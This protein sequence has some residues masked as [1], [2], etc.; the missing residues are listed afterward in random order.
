[1][2]KR[3]HLLLAFFLLSLLLPGAAIAEDDPKPSDPPKKDDA[4][5]KDGEPKPDDAPKGDDEPAEDGEP[6]EG[7]DA[8]KGDGEAEPVPSRPGYKPSDPPVPTPAGMTYLEGGRA[9]IGSEQSFL[10][11]LLAGRPPEHQKL[12]RYE[13]P[14]HAVLL[15]PYFMAK[16]EVT[17][18]QYRVFLRDHETVYDT[19]GGSLANL[20]EIAAHLAKLSKDEQKHPRQEVWLQFYRANKDLIWKAFEARMKDFLVKRLDDTVD[21]IATAK[22]LRFEPLPRTLK[23]RFYSLRPPSNWPDMDPPRGE[24]DHPVRYVS[25]N[26][27]ERFAEWAG[28][29]VPTEEEWEWA[30]RGPQSPTFPWGNQFPPNALFANWGGKITDARYETATLPVGTRNGA[31]PNGENKDAPLDGDGRSWCGCHHMVGNVAEWTSSWFR[32]YAGSRATDHSLMGEWVKVIR[33]G[34]AGDG[35]MLVLRAAC[36]NFI[37]G[38]PDAPPYRENYFKWVGFRL[39]SYMKTGRDQ[40]GPITYRANRARKMPEERLALDRFIGAVTRAWVEPDATPL[41]HV[42]I[43][44]RSHS[45]VFIPQKTFLFEDGLQDMQKAH[46][47][48]TRFK[49]GTSLRKATETNGPFFTL[50]VL[51]S[52]MPITPVLVRKPEEPG[53]PGKKKR[54]GRGRAKAPETVKG[55]AAPGT[56]LLG[57]WF[58]RIALL[59]NSGEFVAFLPKPEG[60]DKKWQTIDVDKLDETPASTLMVDSDLD[61]ADFSFAMP[62]GGKGTKDE[63]HVVVKGR[64]GFEVGA[65]DEA[66]VWIQR[67]PAADLWAKLQ[68]EFAAGGDDK[69]DAKKKSG[70]SKSGKSNSGKEGAKKSA[71]ADGSPKDDSAKDGK[72]SASAR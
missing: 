71:P 8:P 9:M 6:A 15:R 70:K 5:P 57:V 28:M 62:L 46:K 59:T 53:K 25:Y 40:L 60:V 30:A 29:H 55:T 22:K 11:G 14:Y 72:K 38:G 58:G 10:T 65:L 47:R 27:A 43:Q 35:E 44:G 32:P 67:D 68:T 34:G 1:M 54:R 39:A 63:V 4:P 13:T 24:E 48:P 7:E 56:Y 21:E 36:R 17:N 20:D 61:W 42:Y 51:H 41:N 16:H 18:A 31:N 23:L 52:D 66:G 26:D 49:K 64:L 50:G 3:L 19:A 37:G 12:F 2:L 69:D 33:G 45:I